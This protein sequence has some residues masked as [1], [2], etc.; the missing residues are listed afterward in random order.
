MSSQKFAGKVVIVTGSSSGIGQGIALLLGQQGASVTI[1]GRSVEGLQETEKLLTENGVES[2]RILVVQGD[3]ED[4]KTAQKLLEETLEKFG[5]IDVLVNNA[6]TGAK[7]NTDINSEENL[8]F[9]FDVNFKS[10]VRL[11]K[12]MIPELEKT[13]GNIVNISSIDALQAHQEYS[14]YAVSK[15]SLD[16]Y[17]RHLAPSLGRK[18]V[19]INNVNPG[20]IL[21]NLVKRMGVDDAT[22][23]QLVN[24]FVKKDVPLGRTGTPEDIAQAVSYLASSDASYVTGTTLV[25]DGGALV[26]Y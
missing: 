7:P 18:G 16:H 21:T 26:N 11:N 17:M 25:V 20:L 2:E 5:K 1:H 22:F 12:L 19:R 24:D 3:I 10:V 6:G 15:C 9:V 8:D 4:P 13:K 23:E 14:Y